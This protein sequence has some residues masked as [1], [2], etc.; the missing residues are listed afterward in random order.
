MVFQ[1]DLKIVIFLLLSAFNF[2]NLTIYGNCREKNETYNYCKKCEKGFQVADDGYCIDCEGE[3]YNE[4]Y[5]LPDIANCDKI[6]KF[7]EGV[8]CEFCNDGYGPNEDATACVKCADGERGYGLVECTGGIPGCFSYYKYGISFGNENSFDNYFVENYGIGEGENKIVCLS[9][10]NGYLSDDGKTCIEC[11]KGEFSSSGMCISEEER[12]QSC[13]EYKEDKRCQKCLVFTH[14]YLKNNECVRCENNTVSDGVECMEYIENCEYNQFYNEETKRVECEQ[15]ESNY[16]YIDE[17]KKCS[18]CPIDRKC[19]GKIILEEIENC[20]TQTSEICD[21]CKTNYVLSTDKKSCVRCG[22][23]PNKIG[24]ENQCY[25]ELKG[26]LE[27]SSFNQCKRCINDFEPNI[28]GCKQ[29]YFPY[30]SLGYK[31]F[32]PHFRCKIHDVEGNC[33]SCDNGYQVNSEG[34]CTLIPYETLKQL[35]GNRTKINK[36]GNENNEK[37][38]GG[39]NEEEG[40]ESPLT[41]NQSKLIKIH[42]IAF[43][44]LI[45]ILFK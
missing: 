37:L 31:C 45:F 6:G 13:G 7:V 15:C 14:T 34:G 30:T 4:E 5:C 3:N 19:N 43:L 35:Y 42:Y 44:G 2:V 12:V 25:N 27:Y 1:I 26:C 32:L 18:T 28:E 41:E 20:N 24:Y 16:Y 8:K 11:A 29:C 22:T 17:N 39:E 10:N 40:K 38:N 23:S 21:S 9:C 36:K 33:I